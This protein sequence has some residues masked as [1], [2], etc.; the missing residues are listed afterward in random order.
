M[1]RALFLFLPALVF[2]ALTLLAGEDRKP[3]DGEKPRSAEKD[4][5]GK[6]VPFFDA[7]EFIKEYDSNKDG[8][9]SKEELPE[10]FRH[11]FDKLDANKD[12]KLSQE[13]LQKGFAHLQSQRRPSDFVLTLIQLSDCDECCAEELQIVFDLLR[14][15]DKNNDGKI[16]ADELKGGREELV[17]KRIE[18][19]FKDLDT[20][21]DGKI[22]RDEARGHIKHHFD[23]LDSDKDG[24]ISRSELMTAATQKPGT[25]RKT[26]DRGEK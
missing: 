4:K 18:G 13:E 14:K 16:D 1:R 17:N 26:K 19:I 12:G 10:R 7:A 2:T 15:L 3:S 11:N 20:N 24:F 21:K 25:L 6:A 5:T 8:V 9:L 23:E 22:S